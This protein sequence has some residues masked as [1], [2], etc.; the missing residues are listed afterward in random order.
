MAMRIGR[1][2]INVVLSCLVGVFICQGCEV[3]D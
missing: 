1:R 3:A 2:I